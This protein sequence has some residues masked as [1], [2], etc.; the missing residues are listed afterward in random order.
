MQSAKTDLIKTGPRHYLYRGV[1]LS[2]GSAKNGRV[3]IF[4]KT[5]AGVPTVTNWATLKE[6]MV[7]VDSLLDKGATVENSRLCYK[8]GA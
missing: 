4:I 1:G 5:S 7:Y 8:A 6:A 3:T 2:K